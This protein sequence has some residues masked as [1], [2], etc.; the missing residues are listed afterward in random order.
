VKLPRKV[1]QEFL[2]LGWGL[3]KELD[4]L[5]PFAR[6][7]T[8]LRD[9][10]GQALREPEA[11]FA[12]LLKVLVA[13]QSHFLWVIGQPIRSSRGELLDRNIR[14]LLSRKIGPAAT[15][16]LL[17]DEIV[18]SSCV[19][20]NPFVGSRVL[21]LCIPK[22]SAQRQIEAGQSSL[23]AMLPDMTTATFTY[24][25]PGHNELRQY[26]PTYVCGETAVTDVRTENDPSRNYQSSQF[27]ILSLPKGRK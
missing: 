15:L 24:F 8:N 2:I 7:V 13:E 17:V 4:G 18:H 10:S 26:G 1:P 12:S 19:E 25:E 27:R 14:R 20:K 21:A 6:L 11:S 23:L 16:R 5:H 22:S 9:A 3:F